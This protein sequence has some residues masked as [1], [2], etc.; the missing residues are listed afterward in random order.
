MKKTSV[1]DGHI[2]LLDMCMNE[3]ITIPSQEKNVTSQLQ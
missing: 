1:Q 2:K 3:N